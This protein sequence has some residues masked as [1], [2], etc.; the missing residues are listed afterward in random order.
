MKSTGIGAVIGLLLFA[1]IIAA[2]PGIT[3]SPALVGIVLVCGAVIGSV[4]GFA[5]HFLRTP[6]EQRS[7]SLKS[8]SLA[9]AAKGKG[10]ATTGAI[11]LVVGMLFLV[12]GYLTGRVPLL[13][14]V[15]VVAGISSIAGSIFRK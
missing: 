7:P 1:L 11:L 2:T 10:S 8:E 5:L 12:N 14:L 15:G 3:Q 6:D 9:F 13:G 4:F